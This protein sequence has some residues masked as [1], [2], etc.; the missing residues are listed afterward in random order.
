MTDSPFLLKV[1]VAII[2]LYFAA[3]TP[4]RES[5]M[6]EFGWITLY[7]S[8]KYLFDMPS[9]GDSDMR[10]Y[11]IQLVVRASTTADRSLLPALHTCRVQVQW[12][13]MPMRAMRAPSSCLWRLPI[14]SGTRCRQAQNLYFSRFS[15][16]R[17]CSVRWNGLIRRALGCEKFVPGPGPCLAVA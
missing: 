11:F 8:Q 13:A 1:C 14:F 10:H 4:I 9:D 2:L 6:K 15:N 12:M 7:I 5:W 17:L 3:D 16:L